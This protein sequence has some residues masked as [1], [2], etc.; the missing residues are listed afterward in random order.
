MHHSRFY[1]MLRYSP[2]TISQTREPQASRDSSVA[3]EASWQPSG[4]ELSDTRVW[5]ASLTGAVGGGLVANVG[6]TR[7]NAPAAPSAT[8][9][10]TSTLAVGCMAEVGPAMV[11]RAMV[12]LERAAASLPPMST[13]T[14]G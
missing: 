2:V 7:R 14:P 12:P 8:K 13:P 4:G 11:L 3:R 9:H 10:A 1:A 6:S 5:A